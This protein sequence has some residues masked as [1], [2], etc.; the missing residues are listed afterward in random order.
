MS[1]EQM[2]VKLAEWYGYT[3]DFRY[4]AHY[5][6]APGTKYYIGRGSSVLPNY[7]GNLYAVHEL[8]KKLT[9]PQRVQYTQHLIDVVGAEWTDDLG[10]V[11]LVAHATSMERCEA[12]LRMAGLW[13]E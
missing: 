2:R 12:L 5:W 4:D 11:F 8:E 13:E 7:C 9:K 1:P 10:E 6:Y 3:S